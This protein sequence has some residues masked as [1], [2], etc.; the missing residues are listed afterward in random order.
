MV[1]LVILDCIPDLHTFLSQ[2]H[3]I[4]EP[5]RDEHLDLR[6]MLGMGSALAANSLSF[7]M[8]MLQQ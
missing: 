4:Q 2:D 5:L 8:E 6:V 7:T 3:Q 1:C